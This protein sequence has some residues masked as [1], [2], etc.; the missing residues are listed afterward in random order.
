MIKVGFHEKK[1]KGMDYFPSTISQIFF[2]DK[3]LISCIN[4]CYK[5]FMDLGVIL[6]VPFAPVEKDREQLFLCPLFG[7]S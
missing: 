1:G 5:D 6:V 7:H 4:K 3:G 2:M